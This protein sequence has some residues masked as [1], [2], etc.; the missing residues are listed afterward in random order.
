M[1]LPIYPVLKFKLQHWEFSA[2]HEVTC[3]TDHFHILAFISSVSPPFEL[4]THVTI[5]NLTWF[6]VPTKYYN[7]SSPWKAQID[8]YEAYE[9]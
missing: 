3:V 1:D 7:Y 4:I 5:H 8:M 2:V 6:S 9:I